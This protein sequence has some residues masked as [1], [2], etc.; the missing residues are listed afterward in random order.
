LSTLVF[1]LGTVS[2]VQINFSTESNSKPDFGL[3]PK[4]LT[5]VYGIGLIIP[6]IIWG[7]LYAFGN[8]Y[9]YV[10]VLSIYAYS[11]SI[12]IPAAILCIFNNFW[13]EWTV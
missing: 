11:M 5:I 1:V 8:K 3:I 10:N 9:R 13:W 6:L 12:F 7:M 2:N 4:A